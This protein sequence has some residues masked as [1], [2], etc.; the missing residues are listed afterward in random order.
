M[1]TL[2]SS[3]ARVRESHKV[4]NN[5]SGDSMAILCNSALVGYFLPSDA[6]SIQYHSDD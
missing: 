4:H 3:K 5:L 6:V 2:P 1:T